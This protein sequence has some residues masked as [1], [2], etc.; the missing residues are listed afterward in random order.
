VL[1]GAPLVPNEILL[2]RLNISV[3]VEG[4]LGKEYAEGS[5]PFRIAKQ[6][7]IHQ[8]IN[9][10]DFMTS[11]DLILRVKSNEVVLKQVFEKK[12]KKQQA[13][14]NSMILS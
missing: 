8:K 9:I 3:V 12:K 14:Y 13:Y 1:I 10:G 4:D 2:K 6:M 7:G 11:R 5:D